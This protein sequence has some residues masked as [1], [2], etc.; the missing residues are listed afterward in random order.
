MDLLKT[1]VYCGRD[2]FQNQSEKTEDYIQIDVDE[3]TDQAKATG[4]LSDM[5]NK[6]V[7]MV[8]TVMRLLSQ[9]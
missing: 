3:A 2:P 1:C 7:M 4:G 8:I 5:K 6:T 9:P